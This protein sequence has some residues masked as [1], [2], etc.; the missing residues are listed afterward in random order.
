MS[1]YD[2]HNINPYII[3]SG[4]LNEASSSPPGTDFGSRKVKWHEAELI[5]WGEGKIIT[6]GRHISTHKG[7]LFFRRP[8]ME[9][10][11]FS[12]YHCFLVVFDLVYDNSRKHSYGEPENMNN[13]DPA[14][15][16]EAS[17]RQ[18]GNFCGLNLPDSYRTNKF[19]EFHILFKSLF[20][21][22]LYQ[23]KDADL[24]AKSL[25]IQILLN[26]HEE[27]SAF[28]PEMDTR[29]SL[30]LN[31]PKINAVKKLID[32]NPHKW[33]SLAE[34]AEYSGLSRN[35]FC[36]VFHEISGET[37]VEY[38]NRQ[39]IK[40]AKKLLMETNCSIKEIAYELGFENDTYF[41]SLFK[42]KTGL[43]PVEFK[44]KQSLYHSFLD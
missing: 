34:L 16:I 31:K 22:F 25:L 1:I 12:P 24:H 3:K 6:E 11:G 5:T 15:S 18:Y 33:F 27:F 39:K 7:N 40:T 20:E 35:F 29:R 36:S 14:N 41:Y 26:A 13:Q 10:R 23:K 44:Q 37:A 30:R 42:K 4:W 8:G 43:S 32:E 19:D 28:S 21:A 17:E 2:L 38:M 9:V